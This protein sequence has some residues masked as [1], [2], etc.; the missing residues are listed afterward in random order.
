SNGDDGMGILTTYTTAAGTFVG[1][2]NVSG[3]EIVPSGSSARRAFYVNPGVSTFNF[4][5]NTISGEDD[6]PACSPA[7]NADIENN[8]IIGSGSS[9]G[10]GVW[11]YPDAAAFGHA[12]IANNDFSNLS[13]GVSVLSANNVTIENNSFQ[14]TTTG[15]LLDDSFSSGTTNI[16]Y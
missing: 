6:A 7:S 8:R 9:K 14:N 2:L 4:L 11:G 3:N 5:G 1:T 10:I 13:I 16:D 12:L 15:V